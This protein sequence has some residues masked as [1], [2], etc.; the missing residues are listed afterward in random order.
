MFS[1]LFENESESPACEVASDSGSVVI[2][3]HPE[4]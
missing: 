1:R 4:L 2:D 3:K